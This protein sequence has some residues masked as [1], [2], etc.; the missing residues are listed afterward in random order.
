MG[1]TPDVAPR[2]A[3]HLSQYTFDV[4]ISRPRYPECVRRKGEQREAHRAIIVRNGLTA[5]SAARTARR[6]VREIF[7]RDR[8][9]DH[10]TLTL[11]K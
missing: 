5:K 7:P 10:I 8:G 9:W 3:R 2:P 11:R 4:T 1:K 6:R